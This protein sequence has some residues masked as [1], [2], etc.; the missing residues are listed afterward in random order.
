[1]LVTENYENKKKAVLCTHSDSGHSGPKMA[2]FWLTYSPGAGRSPGG[3]RDVAVLGGTQ[4]GLHTVKR[5]PLFTVKAF[6]EFGVRGPFWA[7]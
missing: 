5:K 2:I 4:G 6:P 3:N 1:L 7:A